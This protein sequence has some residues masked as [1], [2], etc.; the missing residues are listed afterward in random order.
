[1]NISQL[2]YFVTV[3]QMEHYGHAA[4]ALYITQPALSN[5]IKRLEREVGFPLFSNVGRNV[6]LT[7]EGKVFLDHVVQSLDTLNSGIIAGQ[8]HYNKRTQT[9]RVGSVASLMRGQLS[10]FLN[11][12]SGVSDDNVEFDISLVSFTREL[13]PMVIEGVF[14]AA[15]CGNPVGEQSLDWIPLFRQDAV[16]IVHESHP[17][18][19]KT[20]VSIEDIKRYPQLSYR[21]P[22][23]M[24][25][26]FKS[27]FVE[28]GLE[29]KLVFDDDISA[30]SVMAV[31]ANSNCVGI[32][33]DSAKDCLWDSVRMIQIEE[34][35]EPYHY[36]GMAY[37]A[38][39]V[40]SP[41]F[42]AFREY[43]ERY[44]RENIHAEATERR[45]YR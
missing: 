34:F 9:I 1:M 28:Y 33:I 38:N 45:Y 3:A 31:T 36:A 29:P 8:E 2:R 20:M 40:H 21:A 16:A 18:A 41:E 6:T 37:L 11:N 26:A 14:D 44:S 7:P 22:S 39:K 35:L 13:L 5:S 4:A 25:Y 27:M 19:D 30:L 42:E 10:S 32:A 24:Y 15:F 23:Y 17:L 43:V 12:Y